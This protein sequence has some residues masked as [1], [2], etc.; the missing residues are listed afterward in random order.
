MAP[1]KHHPLKTEEEEGNREQK[2]HLLTDFFTRKRKGRPKKKGNLASDCIHIAKQGRAASA[3]VN[4]KP[5]MHEASKGLKKKAPPS[6]VLKVKKAR[7]NYSSGEALKKLTTAVNEWNAGTGRALDSNG[8]KR[9]LVEFSNLFDIPFNTFRKYVHPDPE[10]RREVGKSLGRP[11]LLTK[12]NQGFISDAL[13]R[14]DRAKDRS[15]LSGAI[16]VQ[17]ISPHLSRSQARQTFSRT[18]RPNHLNILKPKT[19]TAQVTTTKRSAITVPQQ[20]R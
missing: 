12:G 3:A 6:E 11:S 1:S 18:I 8:E 7:A 17:D 19:M 14:L 5:V 15:D 4:N 13:A 20:F 9:G 2:N 10:K 16:L